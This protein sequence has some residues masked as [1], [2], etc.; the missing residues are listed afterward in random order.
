VTL[1]E[2]LKFDSVFQHRIEIP[3]RQNKYKQ[4]YSI[5]TRRNNFNISTKM[6]HLDKKEKE[7]R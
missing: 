4:T 2:H 1:F 6:L 5:T 7:I 3:Y